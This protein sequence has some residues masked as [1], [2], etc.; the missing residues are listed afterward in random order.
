MTPKVTS[1]T[2]EVTSLGTL[3]SYERC[4]QDKVAM[5]IIGISRATL[6]KMKAGGIL[7]TRIVGVTANGPIRRTSA[8]EAKRYS[9]SLNGGNN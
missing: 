9:D 2:A 7:R 5:E 1:L 8:E 6:A 3:A 4:V